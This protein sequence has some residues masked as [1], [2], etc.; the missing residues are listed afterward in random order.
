MQ[1]RRKAHGA[2]PTRSCCHGSSTMAARASCPGRAGGTGT[3]GGGDRPRPR[4]S[5]RRRATTRPTRHAGNTRRSS[6]SASATIVGYFASSE[7]R[8]RC[9]ARHGRDVAVAEIEPEQLRV[10]GGGQ[11]DPPR[12][13]PAAPA[14]R[15]R[16]SVALRRPAPVAHRRPRHAEPPADLAVVHARRRSARALDGEAPVVHYERMFPSRAGRLGGA[17]CYPDARPAAI[18]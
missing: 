6:A 2:A 8:R 10:V 7:M 15:A 5:I 9:A 1:P 18:V 4:P 17:G 12:G 16:R 13:L 14:Q 3:R 11:R